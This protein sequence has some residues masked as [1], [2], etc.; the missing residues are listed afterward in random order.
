ML[1]NRSKIV[2]AQLIR[3]NTTR[4]ALRLPEL[5]VA[6]A[7]VV[8]RFVGDTTISGQNMSRALLSELASGFR[9][10]YSLDEE[11]SR[12]TPPSICCII[13]HIRRKL[14]LVSVHRNAA[15]GTWGETTGP[16]GLFSTPRETER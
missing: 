15:N 3:G 8:S 6:T 14:V 11:G 9:S 1:E 4:S 7:Q 12:A 5:S 10:D 13:E 16:S 2:P